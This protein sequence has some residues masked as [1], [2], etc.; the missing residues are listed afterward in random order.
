M[1]ARDFLESSHEVLEIAQELLEPSGAPGEVSGAP[2]GEPVGTAGEPSGAT[3]EFWIWKLGCLGWP[4]REVLGKH[5][6]DAIRE[7]GDDEEA[8]PTRSWTFQSLKP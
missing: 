1:I 8:P 5:A 3:G 7:F 6:Q 4:D 2:P